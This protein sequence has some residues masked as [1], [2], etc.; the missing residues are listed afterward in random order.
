MTGG[1]AKEC[2]HFAYLIRLGCAV[3]IT[4]LHGIVQIPPA[5]LTGMVIAGR[6]FSQ[7]HEEYKALGARAVLEFDMQTGPAAG[8]LPDLFPGR[9]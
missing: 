7:R 2:A 8:W 9:E 6:P 3:E 5:F 4:A 1:S